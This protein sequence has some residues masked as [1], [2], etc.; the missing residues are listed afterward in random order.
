MEI[1]EI[2]YSVDNLSYFPRLVVLS[3]CFILF[4]IIIDTNHHHAVYWNSFSNAWADIEGEIWCSE[5]GFFSVNR[6]ITLTFYSKE[7]GEK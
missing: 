5:K 3:Q 4:V 1:A 7:D 6:E 2:Q